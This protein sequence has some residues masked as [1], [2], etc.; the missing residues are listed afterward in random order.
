MYRSEQA[1]PRTVGPHQRHLV[2]SVSK[3]QALSGDALSSRLTEIIDEHLF[4]NGSPPGFKFRQGH[5]TSH[6]NTCAGETKER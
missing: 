3:S 5:F 6:N 1:T 2:V 4:A